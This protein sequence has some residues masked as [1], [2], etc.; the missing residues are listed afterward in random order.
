M[1]S[2]IAE[3]TKAF[4]TTEHVDRIIMSFKH[5]QFVSG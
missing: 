4:E 2:K 3:S 5:P 1:E